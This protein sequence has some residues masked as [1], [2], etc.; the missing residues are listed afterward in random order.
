MSNLIFD[1]KEFSL[2]KIPN[3]NLSSKHPNERLN[4]YEWLNTKK[5]IYH[6]IDYDFSKFEMAEIFK[7]D[8]GN[9]PVIWSKSIL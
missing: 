4:S 5:I 7:M 9:S 3:K 6:F 1:F 8:A 2:K